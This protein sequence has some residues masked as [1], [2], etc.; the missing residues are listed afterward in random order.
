MDR[1]PY[2]FGVFDRF[3]NLKRK[4]GER[5]IMILAIHKFLLEAVEALCHLDCGMLLPLS[6]YVRKLQAFH[7][8]DDHAPSLDPRSNHAE[9]FLLASHAPI[10]HEQKWH[11]HSHNT[12]TFHGTG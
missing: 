12:D 10:R 11:P 8:T 9:N 2:S 1:G 3:R 4:M 5:C 6:Q 7:H